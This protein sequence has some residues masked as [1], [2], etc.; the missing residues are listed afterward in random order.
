MI[1]NVRRGQS[2][3]II[4]FDQQNQ[5]FARGLLATGHARVG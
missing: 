5:C 2:L 1:I 4:G 3:Q